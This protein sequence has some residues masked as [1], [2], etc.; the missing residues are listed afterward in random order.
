MKMVLEVLSTLSQ[1]SQNGF[2][3]NTRGFHETAYEAVGYGIAVKNTNIEIF[4]SV[5]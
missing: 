3:G 1:N 2:H 5:N 4:G